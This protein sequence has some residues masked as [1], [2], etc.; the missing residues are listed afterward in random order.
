MVLAEL[1]DHYDFPEARFWT[2]SEAPKY[3]GR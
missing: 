3:G 2:T 1:K